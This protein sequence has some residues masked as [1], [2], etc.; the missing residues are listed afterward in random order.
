M[1]QIEPPIKK[2]DKSKDFRAFMKTVKADA[3]EGDSEKLNQWHIVWV[4]FDCKDYI[5]VVQRMEILIIKQWGGIAVLTD[6]SFEYK[7]YLDVFRIS[8]NY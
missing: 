8:T 2:V 1:A 6:I 5:E 7:L 4:K 3:K